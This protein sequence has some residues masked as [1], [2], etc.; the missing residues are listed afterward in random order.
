MSKENKNID[1]WLDLY[2]HGTKNIAIIHDG[3]MPELY[4]HMLKVAEHFDSCVCVHESA[5]NSSEVLPIP[6]KLIVNPF[7]LSNSAEE[8]YSTRNGF[9]A[10]NTFTKM[11]QGYGMLA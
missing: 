6:R 11:V 8:D 9:A 1:Q 3:N 2:D 10:I 7:D 4:P 5:F